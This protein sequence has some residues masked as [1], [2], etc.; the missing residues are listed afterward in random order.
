MFSKKHF[1][2]WFS[3]LFIISTI[4]IIAF[5]FQLIKSHPILII[6]N[7]FGAV[8]LIVVY[9][10]SD[11]FLNSDK[12]D[13]FIVSLTFI[14]G[15]ISYFS[16]FPLI[17]YIIFLLFFFRN[18]ILR[19]LIFIS[20]TV[21]FFFLIQKFMLDI[22]NFEIFYWDF[23]VIWIIALYLLS[24]YTGWLVSDMQEVYFGSGIIIFLWSVIFWI[25]N[26]TFGEISVISLLTSIP[27]FFFSIRKYKV[28][29]FLGKV[30]KNL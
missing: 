30:Y 21:A 11:K 13:L 6:N 29:K 18:N 10:I 20:V 28:D 23:S 14:F 24:L 15:F 26:Y 22:I 27:F 16:F 19:F 5:N 12:F 9:Y 3:L 2:N 7:L 25:T 4:I 8:L 17:Y 1:I